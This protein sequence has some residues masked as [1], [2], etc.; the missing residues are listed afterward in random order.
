M[1][2]KNT[3]RP[4]VWAAGLLLLAAFLLFQPGTTAVHADGAISGTVFR[5]FNSNGVLDVNEPGIGGITVT[6]VTNTGATATATT[7]ANGLYNLST[8]V[9]S[10][11]RVEF[12]LPTDG[13]LDFLHPSVAGDTTVQFIDISLGDVANVNVGF[14]NPAQYALAA[15][16]V[17]VPRFERGESV[18]TTGR[19][20]ILGHDYNLNT[21][22]PPLTAYAD[23][24]EVGTIYGLAYQSSSDVLFGGTYIRRG[25]G[26]GPTNTT[27][28]IYKLTGAGAPSLFIDI[29]S[30]VNT[31]ANPHPNG[32][33]HNFIIDTAGYAAV[34]KMGLGDLEISDDEQTLYAVNLN[35]RELVIMPLTFD[36]SGQ[37]VAPNA[38]DIGQITIPV[39]A[40]CNGN[41]VS[42]P[43]PTDWRPFALKYFDGTLYV[44]GI[45]SGESMIAGLGLNPA[46][47]T[48]ADLAPIRPF[49]VATVYEFDPQT[50]SFNP[51]PILSVPLDYA[52][53]PVN[54]DMQTIAND[55]EWLPWTDAWRPNWA[56]RTNAVLP[57]VANPQPILADIELDGR[58]FMFLGFR[59]RFAD[60]AYDVDDLGPDNTPPDTQQRFG[61]D[62]LL[63]CQTA[64]G[65][66][67]LE[68]G[69]V[70]ARSC[71]NGLTGETRTATNP[72][73]PAA[74]PPNAPQEP[75]F[76]HNDQNM[77]GGG[78]T[79]AEWH[80]ETMLGALAVLYGSG[81]V[82]A[83]KYDIFREFEA[84]T[85]TFDTANG[86]RLRGVQ[87]FEPSGQNFG[88]A[89]SLGDIELLGGA[90][91]I[92]IGNRVWQD[93]NANGIQDPGELPIG[94]V[95]VTLHETDGTQLASTTT[96]ANG[97]YY[98]SNYQ[99]IGTVI[100]RISTGA[101]DAR[102]PIGGAAILDETDLRLGNN[103]DTGQPGVVGLRFQN[104]AVPPGAIITSAYIQFSTD[105]PSPTNIGDPANFTIDGEAVGNATPF[106]A[107]VNNISG[108]ARTVAQV[109][110]ATPLWAGRH[111]S[112][113]DQRT[114]DLST[115][116]QEI[117]DGGGWASGNA[118]AFIVNQS[119]SHRDAES[120]DG[121]VIVGVPD[122][123]L[124]PA[125]VIHYTLPTPA[126]FADLQYRS[127]YQ[128][129]VNLN[130]APLD[131]LSVSPPDADNTA[132]G[133]IRDSDGQPQPG[134]YVAADFSTG[135]P[136]ENNHTYDFGF[137]PLDFG[138]L[139]DR[140]NN[141]VLL[142]DGPR[143]PDSG[144]Y[145]G[146]D[147]DADN[148]GQES[149]GTDG[150]DNDGNDDEDGIIFPAG[151]DTWGDGTGELEVTV[152]GGPG[153]V[154]GWA[155]FNENGNFADD[156]SDGVG[157]VSELMFVQFLNNGM[158]PVS[159]NTP[160][161]SVD[162]GT[163]TY[164]GTLNLRFRIFPVN[165][166]LFTVRGVV[167]DGDGCPAVSNG[168]VLM[169]TLSVGL[170]A[171]GEVEDYQQQFTPTAVSLQNIQATTRSTPLLLLLLG[172]VALAL[173]GLGITLSRRRQ[174]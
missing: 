34:G 24:N 42:A 50:N 20:V 99:P 89:G 74:V 83:T 135:G 162:G 59:D 121:G 45:C 1:D 9:G 100:A 21:A 16:E 117:V 33:G 171:G 122:G 173:T 116:V 25:A 12:T 119:T 147:W 96:D 84:G 112:G 114:S 27:G 137:A 11:A 141:T 97:L 64:G 138:D 78:T 106:T 146:L 35:E 170:A 144:L 140:Y 82:V 164:P 48:F 85:V 160:R 92:E 148:D 28:A 80:D 143:H 130:Q 95:T 53:E 2:S 125:L 102:Q 101:D 58:G 55:G 15:A 36:G 7:D 31:G 70:A 68:S 18:L 105:N 67:Q 76:F 86:S 167:L 60:Q 124:A 26:V 120:F 153:C 69:P 88:K 155:D 4:V 49:L 23:A 40:G 61:G 65:G 56:A 52:R 30:I 93:D 159:F 158:T 8:L 154:L 109:A 81:E 111:V 5:D 145:L 57:I 54:D 157:L 123:F 38:G 152:T 107:T 128:L 39:P 161:S 29:T 133:D 43:L 118:M 41:G 132:F 139:P 151:A 71:T 3:N 110:W 150:D 172:A 14:L 22:S 10:E 113:P 131:G 63:A 75:E 13:S 62:L 87:V 115:I 72:P 165:D 163:F 98:F 108:R 94:G 19:S 149:V 169:A 47:S 156:I 174:T 79:S 73:S 91:P 37:P 127:D 136:G 104:L 6:A 142:D 129:R 90:A 66:W 32:V 168:T 77:V 51:T 166:P 103:N 126:N 17:V 134:G 44:G 46:T